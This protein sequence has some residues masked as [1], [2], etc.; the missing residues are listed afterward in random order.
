MPELQVG[1]AEESE[2]NGDEDELVP[3]IDPEALKIEDE[4]FGS[5]SLVEIFKAEY[6][7]GPVTVK[8]LV[9]FG[10]MNL[11]EQVQFSR[12]MSALAKLNHPK[13]VRLLGVC[14]TTRPVQMVVEHCP[15]GSLYELLHNSFEVDLS[16][17]QQLK[18]LEDVAE[19][20]TYLHGKSFVHRDL[21]SLNLMLGEALTKSTD[22]PM[23][24]VS[25]LCSARI[26][27]PTEGWAQMTKD[28]GTLVWS[29]PEILAQRKYDEKVDLYSFAMVMFEVICREPPFEDLDMVDIVR[30]VNSGGR[31]ALEAV[32]PDCPPTLRDLM[33]ACWDHAPER[34]PPFSKVLAE[35]SNVRAESERG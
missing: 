23:V 25:D 13:L 5:N 24:K 4:V 32:P 7:G 27:D 35:I 12:E 20:M 29:A 10:R 16:W 33:I 3:K 21:T 6:K 19:T 22:V 31:P 34:R 14:L 2:E 26:K 17:A 18:M 30:T 11:R 15:G 8:K 1:Q 28:V 9:K